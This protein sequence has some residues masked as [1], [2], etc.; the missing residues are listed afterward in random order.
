MMELLAR[1]AK[2]RI[3]VLIGKSGETKLE[4]EKAA[5]CTLHI[6][7]ETGEVN[8]KWLDESD[9]IVRIKMPDVIRA[10][11]RGQ[12]LGSGQ[13]PCVSVVFPL[14]GKCSLRFS[15]DCRGNVKFV[16]RSII[17]LD[18]GATV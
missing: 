13:G 18:N 10:I 14:F 8:A 1:I 11:G 15:W 12:P 3:G 16:F 7:S 4:I 9:P 2:D 17:S 5:Q 6:D